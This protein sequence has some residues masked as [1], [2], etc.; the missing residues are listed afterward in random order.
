MALHESMELSRRAYA[1]YE[2]RL[3]AKLESEE[4]NQFVAIEPESGDYSIGETLTDAVQ[5]A[6]NAH[7]DRLPFTIRIGHATT[8]DLGVVL[9]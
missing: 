9:S 5:S 3:R 7:P 2:E 4:P 1:I 8:V 6:R